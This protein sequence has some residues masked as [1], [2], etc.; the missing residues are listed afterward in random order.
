M[1]FEAPIETPLVGGEVAVGMLGV[2]AAA[3]AG[4]RALDVA[5]P[6]VD[7]RKQRVLR[8]PAAGHHGQVAHPRFSQPK[9]AA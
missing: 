4:D 9:K 3:G 2:E 7:P 1:Q 6:G 5:E 8:A